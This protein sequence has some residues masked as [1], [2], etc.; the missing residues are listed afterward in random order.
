MNPSMLLEQPKTAEIKSVR[1]SMHS[2]EKAT[3]PR[4]RAHYHIRAMEAATVQNQKEY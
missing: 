1:E 3:K 4:N 2:I